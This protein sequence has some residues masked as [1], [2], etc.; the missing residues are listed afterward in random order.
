MNM[1]FLE[2]GC[3]RRGA[4]TR[5]AT[6]ASVFYAFPLW[7]ALPRPGDPFPNLGSFGLE[8][9]L[10]EMKGKVALVDFWASWCAPCKK[11]F[12]V[13]KELHDKFA[14]RG[15]IL[16][17]VCLDEKKGA[18]EAF[19]KKNPLPGVVLHDAKGRLAEALS[20]EKMPTSFLVGADG[21]VRAVHSG[22]DGEST[23]RQYL[24]EVEA[25]LK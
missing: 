18:M 16:V 5:L 10:P 13:M 21:K 4:L 7:A 6:A 23:R 20:V 1:L 2:S 8:G 9:D 12:P 19:L 25:A 17:A 11:S 15:F 22:F 14:S 3:S 24:T